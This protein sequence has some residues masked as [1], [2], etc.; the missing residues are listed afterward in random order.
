MDICSKSRTT[1]SRTWQNKDDIFS[2]VRVFILLNSEPWT[3][4]IWID[5]PNMTAISGPSMEVLI[6]IVESQKLSN[7]YQEDLE[8]TSLQ[9]IS[10]KN[11]K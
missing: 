10:D 9:N 5:G 1:K 6:Q 4:P 7:A 3:G 8:I 2:T 11:V